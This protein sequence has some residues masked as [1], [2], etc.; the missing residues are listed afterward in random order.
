MELIKSFLSNDIV[1]RAIK[2]FVQAA[3]AVVVAG[4]ANVVDVESGKA[5][6]VA[7]IAAGVS[8]A[9]NTIVAKK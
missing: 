5:L 8:A 1:E 4:Y 6:V 3:V 2:T 7:A 9:W